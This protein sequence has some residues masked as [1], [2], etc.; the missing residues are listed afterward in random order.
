MFSAVLSYYL[1]STSGATLQGFVGLNFAVLQA[2]SKVDPMHHEQHLPCGV[3]AKRIKT[4][5]K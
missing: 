1:V 3:E 4:W 2:E 5:A